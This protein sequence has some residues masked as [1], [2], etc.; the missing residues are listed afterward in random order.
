MNILITSPSLDMRQNVNGISAVV[1]AIVQNS[2]HQ[3]FHY[4]LG[5]NDDQ[6]GGVGWIFGLARQFLSFPGFVR[7]HRIQL[8]HQNFPF[9]AK[10]ILREAVIAALSR[11]LRVPVLLH[12]HGGAFLM[13][14]CPNRLL[15][16]LASYTLRSSRSLVVLSEVEREAL[17]RNFG[18]EGAEVLSNAVELPAASQ[19]RDVLVDDKLTLL[20]LG[21]IH[22]SKGVEDMVDA[23]RILY[24]RKK[25]RFI[26]CGSGPLE[27][28]LRES[29]SNIMNADFEFL[30]VVSGAEKG[31]VIDRCD[32]FLLPSRYGEG[33]P[34]ALLETMA[35]GLVPVVTDDASMKLVVRSRVNGLRVAKRDPGDLVAKI[36]ELLNS[37]ELRGRLSHEAE[38]TV[39]ENYGIGGYIARLEELYQRCA[40]APR[41]AAGQSDTAG[42][43]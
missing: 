23:F 22:E 12:I 20:F 32:I 27:S 2:S 21:R 29:C 15:R 34:M 40:R 41:R 5:R 10:G 14:G 24:P 17:V 42:S 36:E 16:G 13:D 35:K 3:Y 30:G 28:F 33:L 38:R 9:D 7:R 26:A 39:R 31:A 37:P 19:K 11:L 8:V 43:A 18:I 6:R 25:F 1:N 4:R